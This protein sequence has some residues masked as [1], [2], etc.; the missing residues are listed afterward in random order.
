MIIIA[1]IINKYTS[2]QVLSL[3]HYNR[4]ISV[5]KMFLYCTLAITFKFNIEFKHDKQGIKFIFKIQ[6]K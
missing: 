3:Y 5:L 6:I 2:Q 1:N 4:Y